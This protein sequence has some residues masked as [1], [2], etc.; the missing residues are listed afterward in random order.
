MNSNDISFIK[1][2]KNPYY[3]YKKDF[4]KGNG[5]EK[6]ILGSYSFEGGLL[7]LLSIFSKK[8]SIKECPCNILLICA[9]GELSNTL[10]M[11]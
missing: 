11:D 3:D 9:G 6:T 4:P 2:L 7:I 10:I 1:F 5:W 8:E